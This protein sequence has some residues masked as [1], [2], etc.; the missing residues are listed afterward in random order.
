MV[1][2]GVCH[3]CLHAADGSH[4]GIPMPI[5]LGDEGAGVVE[6]VGP[7][8]T[9]VEVGAHVVLSWAPGCGACRA[10]AVG[11][12]ALCSEQPPLGVM[13]DGETRFSL[14][15]EAVYHYGP[16][17]YSPFVTVS[18]RAAV[19]IDDRIPLEVAALVGCSVA[20]GVG[21]VVNAAQPRAGESVAVFGCGG[22]GLN[23]VQGAA[24]V[25]AHPIIG[26]DTSEAKLS[27]ARQLGATHTLRSDQV[28]AG[29]AL[30]E[31]VKT[32]VDHAIVAVGLGSVVEQALRTL[33]PMGTLVLVGN[34]P[35]DDTV[36][37]D[38]HAILYG[39]RRLVGSVYG[40]SSPLVSFGRLLDLYA[41]GRIKLEE[42]VTRRYRLDQANEAFEDLASDKE[43]R[44]LIVF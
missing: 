9:R 3:S 25:G 10:C 23:A 32:G 35:T 31:L 18:E 6:A 11:R 41:A 19:P 34:P 17:T 37:V 42:L 21:A 43:G 4:H 24:L 40:S 28:E 5:V 12:P 20:T 13:E 7:G 36:T 33:A 30:S 22:V 27:L 2:T 8:C 16:A 39:E 1:A 44:G 15:D 14:G 38:P 26:I 29:E